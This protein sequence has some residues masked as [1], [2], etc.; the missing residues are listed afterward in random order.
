LLLE[1]SPPSS[2]HQITTGTQQRPAGIKHFPGRPDSSPAQNIHQ[3]QNEAV[4]VNLLRM[5]VLRLFVLPV[6]FS[7]LLQF[8]ICFSPSGFIVIAPASKREQKSQQSEN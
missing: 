2:Q 1:K 7:K 8:Q 4:E 6:L 3:Q 5:M